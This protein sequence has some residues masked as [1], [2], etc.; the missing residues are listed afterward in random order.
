MVAAWRI[1]LLT[2]AAL[3]LSACGKGEAT[4]PAAAPSSAATAPQPPAPPVP[5]QGVARKVHEA[6]KL[7]EFDYGYPA[8][9][10]AIPALKSWLENDLT[11]QK[12]DL[13]QLA[14]EVSA[15]AKE[16]RID[17]R[18]Y[19]SGVE[20]QVVTDL[21]QWLRWAKVNRNSGDEFDA[22]LD[23]ASVT[24]ILG[25]ANG[26]GFDRIGFLIDPYAAGPYA[27]GD[28]EVTLPVTGKVLAAV[29][30]EFRSAFAAGK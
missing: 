18:P 13:A 6:S 22:C 14:A 3:V 23:P 30:P 11:M 17:F 4:A 29:K 1:G 25:S 5:V 2:G 15:E 24:V 10:Q 27:E 8:A 21:P 12:G 19:T 28:Y 26:Q 20:W 16:S 9:A 7:Y